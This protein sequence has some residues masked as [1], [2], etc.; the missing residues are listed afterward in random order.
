[1][2]CNKPLY[3]VFSF[4]Y[5]FSYVLIL[6]IVHLNLLILSILEDEE[7]YKRQ[8]SMWIDYLNYHYLSWHAM[9]VYWEFLVHKQAMI[10]LI[11]QKDKHKSNIYSLPEAS[12]ISILESEL[13]E[14]SLCCDIEG[15]NGFVIEGNNVKE[16]CVLIGLGISLFFFSSASC[17]STFSSSESWLSKIAEKKSIGGRSWFSWK[18][19]KD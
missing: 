5:A 18:K 9:G 16:L 11:F 3:D 6:Q 2:N 7:K 10:Y 15:A 8:L 12:I 19:A 17:S 4:S 13:S 1:L 14:W